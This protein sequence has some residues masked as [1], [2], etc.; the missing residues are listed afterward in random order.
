MPGTEA[1]KFDGKGR[2]VRQTKSLQQKSTNFT[3]CLYTNST[4]VFLAGKELGRVWA[5]KGPVPPLQALRPAQTSS[6][7]RALRQEMERPHRT[8]SNHHPARPFIP[9]S[10]PKSGYWEAQKVRL[11]HM[12]R[13]TPP[14]HSP[15]HGLLSQV[16]AGRT[17]LK[18][19]H[20]QDAAPPT[21]GTWKRANQYSTN[22]PTSA[23]ETSQSVPRKRANQCSESQHCPTPISSRA[24][25]TCSHSRPRWPHPQFYSQSGPLG[26]WV[27]EGSVTCL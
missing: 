21:N 4:T 6:I 2:R 5:K 22:E 27:Q 26:L 3:E 23:Q 11:R 16:F 15:L 17:L 7:H 8:T 14:A 10:G 25:P 12:P 18:R 9:S 24:F 1:L 19:L 20:V 13:E